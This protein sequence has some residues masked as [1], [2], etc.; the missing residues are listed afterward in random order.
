MLGV[1]EEETEEGRRVG[2]GRH[3]SGRDVIREGGGIGR[4]GGDMRGERR[5]GM[6]ERGE[7]GVT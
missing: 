7:W 4:P 3:Q 5:G 6:G 1:A 2:R